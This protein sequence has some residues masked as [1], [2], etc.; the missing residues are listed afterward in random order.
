MVLN[1]YKPTQRSFFIAKTNSSLYCY[2][3][4][5]MIMCGIDMCVYIGNFTEM[6]E[7]VN[8]NYKL[9]YEKKVYM[10]MINYSTNINKT[11]NHLSS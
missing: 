5:F 7:W 6:Y 10:V 4:A 2:N 9:Y 11:N 1:F 8:N 3:W